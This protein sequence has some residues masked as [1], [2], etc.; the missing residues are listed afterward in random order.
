MKLSNITFRLA[1]SFCLLAVVL[2]VVGWQG[3]G[4]LR[5]LNAQMQ[6]TVGERWKEVQLSHEALRLS[7]LN[8]RITLTIFL[9]DNP[10]EIKRL[11]AEREANTERISV[12]L[13]DLEP[14]LDPEEQRLFAPVK[15]ARTPYVESYQKALS[16]LLTEQKPDDA[17][18]MM[19]EDVRPKLTA[20]HDA[21]STFDEHETAEIDQAIQQSKA[22]YTAG[23]WEFLLT[24]V[25]AGAITSAI[26]IFTVVRV[27]R[28]IANRRRAEQA[29]QEG[30]AQLEQRIEERTADLHKTNEALQAEID[31]RY[32]AEANLKASFKEI[33]DLKYALDEH[34][35]V[36]I[37]DPQGKITYANDKFREISKYTREE[38]LGQDH[39]IV[40]SG[41]HPKEFMREL[42][43]T[44]SNGKVWH[45]EIRNRAKDGSLYWVDATIIPFLNELGKPRQYV[46]IR[47]DIS[48]SKKNE[49]RMK[50]QYDVSGIL[51]KSDTLEQAK[52]QI[53]Q[54][55]C[56]NLGWDLGGLWIVDSRENVL[57]CSEM[58]GAQVQLKDFKMTSQQMTFARGLGLPGRIWSSG[59]P[60]WIQD[61]DQ[62]VNCPRSAAATRSGL[63]G[64]LGFPIF[65]GKE[66]SAVIELFSHEPQ[67]RDAS[68]LQSLT[69]LGN[70]IGQFFQRRRLEAQ[71]LQSQKMKTVGR[72]AGGVAH[73]FNSILTAII[74]QSEL[75]LSDLPPDNPMMTCAREI[76]RAADRAAVLTRQLL[77]YGR[78]QMLQP[79]I[80]NLNRVLSEMLGTLQHLM[81]REVDVRIMPAIGLKS[82]KIDRGQMEQ[83][84]VDIAMNAADAMPNGGNFTLETANVE[85]DEEYV[86]P[87]PGLKPGNYVMLGLTD[88]GTGMAA[89][90]KARVFEPFFSTKGVGQ[91]TGLGLASCYGILKQSDGHI[92]VYSEVARGTTFKIYLPQ[93]EQP[94][95]PPLPQLKSLD[96]PRGTETILLAEDDPSLLEMSSTLLR[97]LGYTVFTA[98]NG[99]EALSLKNQRDI[100]HIDLLLTDIVMPHMSGKE[101]SDRILA[102]Y[103]RTKILFTSAFTENAI[104]SQGIL[105]GGVKVLQ[106]P[107]TPSAMANKV[108]E[109][110]DQK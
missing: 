107:F 91:G 24:L 103:P 47:T 58:W 1:A 7:E 85:L 2:S 94:S 29:L 12:L 8:S 60:A 63:R 28:E 6:R 89:E 25:L 39:R 16:L 101:L 22:D 92:N 15:A 71:L 74:G 43:I 35:I 82:V 32:L 31:E 26:A 11:L 106:K 56:E 72:L 42:W 49:Q 109:V 46:S 17:R 45:G 99:L 95:Q 62:E 80:L 100:G 105:K 54:T 34:A 104:I 52:S 97:R 96:L 44:I 65:I 57:R 50:V 98:V 19:M 40:N 79:E 38:L 55:L 30:Y 67:F 18:K 20:Y 3:V 33:T 36:A 61:V 23:L 51:V 77:A 78:K 5:Q 73:E 70:Q 59:Q 83:V 21:W 110:L 102:I 64:G 87:F 66:V 88:T 27:D 9:L 41:Y 10:D 69:T 108:R 68:L 86:R 90:V 37:T 75:L 84:L 76:R 48:A 53:L 14:R 81:G 93:V 4:H 13:R